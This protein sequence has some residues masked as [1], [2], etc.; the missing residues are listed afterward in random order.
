MKRKAPIEIG[1]RMVEELYRLFPN[2]SDKNIARRIGCAYS[3][4]GDW[5]EGKTPGGL[6]LASLCECGGD[7]IWVLT[8]GSRNGK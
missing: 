2:M 7:V 3:V 4:I 6:Y 8:G 1:F 5:K